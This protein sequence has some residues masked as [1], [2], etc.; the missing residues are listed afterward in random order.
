MRNYT[1]AWL[2]RPRLSRG[3]RPQSQFLLFS[4]LQ[5]LLIPFNL[6][7]AVGKGIGLKVAELFL[8]FQVNLTKSFLYDFL[9]C[10]VKIGLLSDSKLVVY[11]HLYFLCVENKLCELG[12]RITPSVSNVM[13]Q[14]QSRAGWEIRVQRWNGKLNL[15]DYKL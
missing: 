15:S 1:F 7:V 11:F 4:L 3:V 2:T 5:Q 6:K 10:Q 12:C 14:G 8:E 9:T 13:H